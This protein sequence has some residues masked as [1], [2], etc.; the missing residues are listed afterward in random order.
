MHGV[1]CPDERG[2]PSNYYKATTRDRAFFS[3]TLCPHTTLKG[4][5]GRAGS[6]WCEEQI[7]FFFHHYSGTH[8]N[9]KFYWNSIW[10]FLRKRPRHYFRGYFKKTKTNIVQVIV[11]YRVCFLF[12]WLVRYLTMYWTVL[13]LSGEANKMAVVW[14]KNVL[15]I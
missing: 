5:V 10:G 6:K 8:L 7:F 13:N 12:F 15:P 1:R 14:W 11:T 2:H 9:P 4:E 3:F